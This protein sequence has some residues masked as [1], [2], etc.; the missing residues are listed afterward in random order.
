MLHIAA[1][2]QL[3]GH[4]LRALVYTVNEMPIATSLIEAGID[5]IVTDAIDRFI[6]AME[7]LVA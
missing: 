1:R 3:H 7:P 5:G 4:G 6:P 2:G